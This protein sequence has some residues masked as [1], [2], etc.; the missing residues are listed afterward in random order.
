[1]SMFSGKFLLVM[2]LLFCENNSRNSLQEVSCVF[3]F[4]CCLSM[5]RYT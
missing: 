2:K 3:F 5:G 4:F 1:M